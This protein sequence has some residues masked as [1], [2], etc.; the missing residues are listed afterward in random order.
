MAR[1]V[2]GINPEELR[3]LEQDREWIDAV[4]SRVD[5]EVR[6][7]SSSPALSPSLAE[8]RL[9]TPQE[10]LSYFLE[11]DKPYIEI[12]GQAFR[13]LREDETD[14]LSPEEIDQAAQYRLLWNENSQRHCVRR[15]PMLKITAA[16][17]RR[18]ATN[19]IAGRASASPRWQGWSH[20]ISDRAT[21]W[22]SPSST[23]TGSSWASK[24]ATSVM[25]A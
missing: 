2:F 18:C 11:D 21:H 17:R 22:T 13:L 20:C 7:E 12:E 24:G 16:S 19:S 8:K 6:T 25:T 14:N 10:V 1:Q 5:L 23:Q 4:R 3:L 9:A 15:H